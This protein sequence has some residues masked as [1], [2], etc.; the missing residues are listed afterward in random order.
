MDYFDYIQRVAHLFDMHHTIYVDNTITT[1]K[2]LVVDLQT[3]FMGY[4]CKLENDEK[5]STRYVF[6]SRHKIE[7]YAQ[8]QDIY[9]QTIR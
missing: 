3:C 1:D 8:Q 4:S 9:R 6:S 7:R 2:L 5:R